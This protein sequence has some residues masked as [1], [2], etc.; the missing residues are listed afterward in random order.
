MSTSEVFTLDASKSTFIEELNLT[1]IS[2]KTE[3]DSIK[4]VTFYLA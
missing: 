1:I 3:I 4:A 2:P